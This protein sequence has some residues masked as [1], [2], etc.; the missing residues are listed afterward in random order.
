MKSLCFTTLTLLGMAWTSLGA[1]N[2]I[3]V[4]R[5]TGSKVK[6]NIGSFLGT[7]YELPTNNTCHILFTAFSR[8]HIVLDLSRQVK[9]ETME[10]SD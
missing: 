4:K 10:I 8:F 5:I 7:I 1:T 3:L 9:Q 6:W 2:S